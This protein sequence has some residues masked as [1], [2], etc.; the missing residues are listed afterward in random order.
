VERREVLP[1][2][3]GA[4]APPWSAA[5][6]PAR[7]APAELVESWE[8][9]HRRDGCAAL[10][11]TDLGVGAGATPRIA[12]FGANAW[13]VAFDK[14]GLPGTTAEGRPT[15]DGGRS[16]FGIAGTAV[17]ST[18]K[19]VD[20]WS[21]HRVWRDGS[22]ADYGLEGGGTGPRWL[23][24]LYVRGQRCEYNVWSAV[25]KAHLELLLDGIRFV[26]GAP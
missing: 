2:P 19:R 23:A 24:Q 22:R 3:A 12:S 14:P 4:P 6:I 13:A 18:V 11:L 7:Q 5:K 20:G 17:D 10:A 25:G 8:G 15:A 16:A 26:E 21:D 9:N 1:E